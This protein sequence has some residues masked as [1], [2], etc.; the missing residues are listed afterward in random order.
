M[1]YL[2]YIDREQNMESV[3]TASSSSFHFRPLNC[4][5]LSSPLFRAIRR[6][7][8]ATTGISFFSS[9]FLPSSSS[10]KHS[11]PPALAVLIHCGHRLLFLLHPFPSWLLRYNASWDSGTKPA[12][13]SFSS[14]S[15]SKAIQI[16]DQ[17]VFSPQFVHR[18]LL[19]G[20]TPVLSFQHLRTFFS[21]KRENLGDD[22]LSPS[23]SVG[24]L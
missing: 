9:S 21:R 15:T 11:A 22:I 5:L 16:S 6:N 14:S 4:I 3:F 23:L 10:D 12:L 7:S 18:S 8:F 20:R 17:S 13:N 24:A 19:F 2:R 1:E